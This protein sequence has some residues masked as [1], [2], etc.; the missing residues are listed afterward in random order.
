VARETQPVA[1]PTVEEDPVDQRN[2]AERPE[3]RRSITP[4]PAQEAETPQPVAVRRKEEPATQP[5][6]EERVFV[7][8]AEVAGGVVRLEGIAW[9][10]DR[11][12]A[13]VNGRVVGAGDH[14]ESLTI[15]KV[16]RRRILLQDDGGSTYV[17]QL[18]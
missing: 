12:F 14:I 9:S 15:T 6:L 11:P 10:S 18:R 7:G 3:P 2:A 4:A 17:L 8:E 13:L 1:P 16:E 5:A